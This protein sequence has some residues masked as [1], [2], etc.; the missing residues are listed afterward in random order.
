MEENRENKINKEAATTRENN[1]KASRIAKNILAAGLAAGGVA[2]FG[3]MSVFAAENGEGGEEV[4]TDTQQQTSVEQSSVVVEESG[5][6]NSSE[7]NAA[8]ASEP[9]TSTPS[10]EPSSEE[11]HS[12]ESSTTEPSTASNG[13]AA[14][15]EATTPAASVTES[16]PSE[17]PAEALADFQAAA[18]P[19]ADALSAAPVAAAA[20][21]S[22]SANT[23]TPAGGASSETTES[24]ATGTSTTVTR[25]T[26]KS[27]DGVTTTTTTTTTTVTHDENTCTETK[28]EETTTTIEPSENGYDETKFGK[29]DEGASET[30]A[31]GSKVTTNEYT[32]LDGSK[33]T[34]TITETTTPG[35][36]G[37][38]VVSPS[39]GTEKDAV[40]VDQN[41]NPIR[42][43]NGNTTV[44]KTTEW[45][46]RASELTG[47]TTT[48]TYVAITKTELPD[49]NGATEVQYSFSAIDLETNKEV[50]VNLGNMKP[51]AV[52]EMIQAT[53]DNNGGYTVTYNGK[54][55][56]V[57]S[58]RKA[59]EEENAK[60]DTGTI[61]GKNEDGKDE[62]VEVDNEKITLTPEGD[63]SFSFI[64]KDGNTHQLHLNKVE[65]ELGEDGFYFTDS[66]GHRIRVDKQDEQPTSIKELADDTY[67]VVINGKTYT[68]P[69]S[70]NGV[71]QVSKE[72]YSVLKD[73][74]NN[75][76][77]IDEEEI[78]K[79]DAGEAIGVEVEKD[80]EG[81][82]Y[83]ELQNGEKLIFEKADEYLYILDT[84]KKEHI[85]KENDK[86]LVTKEGTGYKVTINNSEAFSIDP[87]N[88]IKTVTDKDGSHEVSIDT[89]DEI[90][91]DENNGKYEATVKSA[92]GG[93][94]TLVFDKPTET[95]TTKT[96][97]VINNSGQSEPLDISDVTDL[98]TLNLKINEE[99][100]YQITYNSTKYTVDPS[101]I[102]TTNTVDG[103]EVNDTKITLTKVEG[104][105][106]EYSGTLSV[107]EGESKKDINITVTKTTD[108][109]GRDK[110]SGKFEGSEDS[111]DLT[112][113]VELQNAGYLLHFKDGS[114][115][116]LTD[117]KVVEVFFEGGY[118]VYK[119]EQNVTRILADQNPDNY[120]ITSWITSYDGVS[121]KIKKV[122]NVILP[123]NGEYYWVDYE[124][125]WGQLQRIG[126]NKED[127]RYKKLIYKDSNLQMI[128]ELLGN[129]GVT[130]NRRDGQGHM[131]SNYRFGEVKVSDND[132]VC[133]G[134]NGVYTDKS[135]EDNYASYVGAIDLSKNCKIEAANEAKILYISLKEGQTV[136]ATCKETEPGSGVYDVN[137]SSMYIRQGDKTA[138]LQNWKKIVIVKDLDKKISEDIDAISRNAEEM[139]KHQA[140]D[141]VGFST[142][143]ENNEIPVLDVSE[144]EDDVV[145]YNLEVDSNGKLKSFID[146]CKTTIKLKKDQVI[147]FNI[148]ANKNSNI[149]LEG[150]S[151]EIIDDELSNKKIETKEDTDIG[152][153]KYFQNIVFNFADYS[154]N[155][156]FTGNKF[157]GMVIAPKATV[158]LNFVTSGK[159]VADT[160][161]TR[162]VE[163]HYTGFN[164]DSLDY[165]PSRRYMVNPDPVDAAVF[166][167]SNKK[168]EINPEESTVYYVTP[169]GDYSLRKQEKY[170]VIPEQQ[171]SFKMI[172]E[173]GSTVYYALPETFVL[174]P[175]A[176]YSKTT[177]YEKIEIHTSK[178]SVKQYVYRTSTTPEVP[179]V[180]TTPSTPETP[181]TPGTPETPGDP[182]TP[183]SEER[184]VLGVQRPQEIAEAA[185]SGGAVLGATRGRQVAT[186]D[187]ANVLAS[188]ALAGA[189][190]AGLGGFGL[191]RRLRNRRNRRNRDQ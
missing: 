107:G 186:G 97:K 127:V 129:Y 53:P 4:S 152:L 62:N 101:S 139:H 58:V 71:R 79:N 141:G 17:S 136:D 25:I 46:E 128:S 83:Y 42:D 155:I 147:V 109:N 103:Q 27:E 72:S 189:S 86:I 149:T 10:T 190:G 88:V 23:E 93:T 33:T 77:K 66:Y 112:E 14:V 191:F 49:A 175:S 143:I 165:I 52:P 166:L 95:K 178:T 75:T 51:D 131:D 56:R 183:V 188:A 28:T 7:N 167:N 117:G 113:L 73:D 102:R 163:W 172:Y 1:G 36:T 78:K 177:R 45:E 19:V 99:G 68:L 29:L 134:G 182:I 151:I 90:E 22:D 154:G 111:F 31:D 63:G 30:V 85:Y 21:S 47:T 91:V 184:A 18:A 119:D 24:A 160:F 114:N 39:D 59:T 171:K 40:L 140:T 82:Y 164:W 81:K 34:E 185:P 20:P 11:S 138:T 124:N 92:D 156:N 121:K 180:P 54:T 69:G 133:N 48:K 126:I 168:V 35:T 38:T 115:L 8:P 96:I 125:E 37:E 76:T 2:A 67:E 123:Q 162:G 145:Y 9:S 176:K 173:E 181:T 108:G 159:V 116:P 15:A 161:K 16:L 110:F 60:F 84:D 57:N 142:S 64:G 94:V 80:N 179:D 3:D 144:R 32:G 5:N 132:G 70:V 150:Y 158:D 74:K 87:A 118:F 187:E 157:S 6:G 170:Y 50:T 41:G 43:A 12:A 120:E 106:N 122:V 100:K 55:Y 44:N 13:E 89:P 61:T 169:E 148:Q 146:N 98:E 153:K 130:A 137:G 174:D 104:K 26:E 65:E 135:S 105:E